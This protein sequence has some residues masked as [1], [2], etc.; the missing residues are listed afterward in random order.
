MLNLVL[1][2][3]R[4]LVRTTAAVVEQLSGPFPNVSP[5]VDEVGTDI[6]M[7]TAFPGGRCKSRCDRPRYLI[8]GV[9]RMPEALS[10]VPLTRST[11]A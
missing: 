5:M 11:V 9:P 4:L 3:I 7:C 2:D 6:L 8:S 1:L 10:E